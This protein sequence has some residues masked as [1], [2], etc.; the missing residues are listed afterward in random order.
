MRLKTRLPRSGRPCGKTSAKGDR[1]ARV[2]E[3]IILRVAVKFVRVFAHQSVFR[4][5]FRG[6]LLAMKLRGRRRRRI[7]LSTVFYVW[8]AQHESPW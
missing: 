8:S 1:L 2:I 7:V 6:V 3:A 5:V 4:L